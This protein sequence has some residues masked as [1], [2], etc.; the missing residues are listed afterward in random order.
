MPSHDQ[1]SSG[2][3]SGLLRSYAGELRGWTTRI[4][5]RY[6]LA[7]ALLLGAAAGLVGAIAVGIAALFHWLEATYGTNTAYAAIAGLL[8]ALSLVSAGVAILLVKGQLPPIPRPGRRHTKAVG[9]SLAA[10]AI[11]ATTPRRGSL[12]ADSATGIMIGLAGA[13]VVGWL[14]SSRLGRSRGAAARK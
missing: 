8:V 2:S 4:V 11:L 14:V 1:I 6:A 7:V 3:L 12:N 10:K 9:R 5:I 13:C